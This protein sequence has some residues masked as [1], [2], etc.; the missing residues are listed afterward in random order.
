MSWGVG[1][2]HSWCEAGF[3]T[4]NY[5]GQDYISIYWGG[6]NADFWVDLND[7]ERDYIEGELEDCYF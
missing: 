7:S 5:W 6:H 4:P 3:E 1:P 2:V